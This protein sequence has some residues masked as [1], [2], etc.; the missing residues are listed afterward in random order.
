MPFPSKLEAQE[1]FGQLARFSKRVIDKALPGTPAVSSNT[2]SWKQ[3]GPRGAI[4]H[5]T[6]SGDWKGPVRWFNAFKA[7]SAHAVVADRLEAA[8]AGL[9]DDL[10][11]VKALPA[12]VIQCVPPSAAAWHAT[13]VN[14]LCYG[15]ENRN[16]GL[17]KRDGPGAPWRH[18]PAAKGSTTEWTSAA[19]AIAGKSY[20]PV[21]DTEGYEP[22]TKAQLVANVM[23]LRYVGAMRGGP[24]EPHL[25]LPHSAVQTNKLDAG[26]LFP[27]HEVRRLACISVGEDPNVAFASFADPPR[28]TLTSADDLEGV[29][30]LDSR[31][32][33]KTTSER[34]AVDAAVAGLLAVERDVAPRTHPFAHLARPLLDHLGFFVPTPPDARTLDVWLR[35]ACWIF[36][37]G[38]KLPTTSEPDNATRAALA[39][40]CAALGLPTA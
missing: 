30:G 5:Y 27:I 12:T 28:S 8:A 39:A 25:V 38:A 22:Y 7:S 20:A 23:L 4:L 24:L 9:A 2:S 10:P 6:A 13:W 18:W 36:Q 33:A 1:F 34:D 17:V 19:P 21:S 16:A 31:G 11:L 29:G 3:G 26:P 14:G 40:R 37:T 15:I 32:S 35:R